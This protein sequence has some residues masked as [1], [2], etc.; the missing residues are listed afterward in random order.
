M[1]GRRQN[2]CT[3]R[4][5]MPPGCPLDRNTPGNR[6]VHCTMIHAGMV[7]LAFPFTRD[8][9]RHE[10]V[11]CVGRVC[12]VRR[13]KPTH[14]HYEVVLLQELILW[15]RCSLC[16]RCRRCLSFTR[17]STCLTPFPTRFYTR[18]TT[19]LLLWRCR[20]GCALR[21][22]ALRRARGW[23]RVRC[24]NAGFSDKADGQS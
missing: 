8:G 18:A 10:L 12:L 3:G 14:W 1:P 7:T 16:C 9:F 17:F 5:R 6:P 13:S 4:V 24:E 22:R 21:N 2:A 19:R 11:E 20:W 15:S 23:C